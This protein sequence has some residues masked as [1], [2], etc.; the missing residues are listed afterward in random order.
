MFAL[1]GL[2]VIGDQTAAAAGGAA[3]AALLAS[4]EMLHGL[5]KRLTW[6]EVR[7]AVILAV[8]TAVILPL[9]PDKPVDPWNALNLRE[10]W[11]FTLLVAALSYLG[12]IA[13]RVLGPARGLLYSCIAGS[14]VSSTAMTLTLA[15]HAWGGPPA[16]RG[17]IAGGD[18]FH[19]A[20]IA[21]FSDPVATCVCGG[22]ARGIFGRSH[23]GLSR[24]LLMLWGMSDAEMPADQSR[25][26]FDLKPLLLFAA[27]FALVAVVSVVSSRYFGTAS[28][29]ITAAIS[30]LVDVDV[31]V[32]SVLR[33]PSSALT[34]DLAGAVLAAL[35]S[36]AAV[37]FPGSR[38]G[39]TRA[40]SLPLASV[41]LA[42]AVAAL[43]AFLLVP[44]IGAP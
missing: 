7:S 12:Y 22:G 44:A 37:R 25:N 32:L 1:G 41:N 9:L 33:L 29:A 30:G 36:N 34:P 17:G 13:I 35:A 19:P 23:V 2:A 31:A 14:L 11:I 38:S 15:R 27:I 4:R 43:M 10:I 5:L 18:G 24:R 28:L 42:A 6:I 21:V 8:M 26:P 16:G 40:F 20:R 39:R 3:L